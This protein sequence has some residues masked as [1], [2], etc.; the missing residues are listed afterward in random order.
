M[1]KVTAGQ[2]ELL[3][4]LCAEFPHCWFERGGTAI[5]RGG[6]RYFP[7][8]VSRDRMVVVEY[9][10]DYWHCWPGKY[11]ASFYHSVIGMSARDVWERDRVRMQA[12]AGAGYKSVIVWEHEFKSDCDG[13]V[14]R[15]RKCLDEEA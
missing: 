4:L 10:G 13:M 12:I 2:K 6:K 8:I 14:D 1:R 9:Y 11:D 15:V 3:R 7:D 5:V